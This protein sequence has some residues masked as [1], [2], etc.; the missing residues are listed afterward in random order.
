MLLC[1]FITGQAKIINYRNIWCTI[2]NRVKS[3]I[4]NIKLKGGGVISYNKCP[5]TDITLALN[6]VSFL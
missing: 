6:S 5:D 2:H 4:M 1:K 3:L